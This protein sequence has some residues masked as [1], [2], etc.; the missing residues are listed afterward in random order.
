M[1]KIDLNRRLISD[2]AASSRGGLKLSASPL[3]AACDQTCF[4]TPPLLNR[5]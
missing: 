1:I 3:Q 4:E 5:I 2:G